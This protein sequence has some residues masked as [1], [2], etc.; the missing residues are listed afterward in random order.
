MQSYLSN[1]ISFALGVALSCFI[2]FSIQNNGKNSESLPYFEKEA[3][4]SATAE[5][6]ISP[7]E[8]KPLTTGSVEN[9]HQ[10]ES[11]GVVYASDY[12]KNLFTAFTDNFTSSQLDAMG[13]SIGN[14]SR[15]FE[16]PSRRINNTYLDDAAVLHLTIDKILTNDDSNVREMMLALVAGSS[17]DNKQVAVIELMSSNRLIDHDSVAE[18]IL[19]IDDKVTQLKLVDDVIHAGLNTQ[20]LL[21][22]LS[23]LPKDFTDSANTSL[24]NSLES[25]LLNSEDTHTRHILMTLISPKSDL[26]QKVFADALV[27]ANTTFAN[28][29]HSS[30]SELNS[31]IVERSS[32]FSPNQINDLQ[33]LTTRIAA[34]DAFAVDT[35]IKALELLKNIE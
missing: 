9:V 35:R 16:E 11:D 24:T 8:I 33:Q 7:I 6:V 23:N 1:L 15:Y 30:L 3:V 21:L 13:L 26:G 31:W 32:S 28:T 5:I 34:N 10:E 27:S 19:N 4:N 20:S 18:L 2:I 12:Q 22:L 14:V 29:S 17:D 25:T